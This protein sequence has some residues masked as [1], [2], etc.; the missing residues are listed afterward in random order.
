[1]YRKIAAEIEKSDDSLREELNTLD[2]KIDAAATQESVNILQEAVTNLTR[3]V[4]N[5]TTL[6]ENNNN[7]RRVPPNAAD[8]HGRGNLHGGRG[9]VAARGIQ[10][11]H[12]REDDGLGKP[13][14]SIPTLTCDAEDVEEY[15]MWELKIEKLWRLHDYSEE[16]K[17]KLA[18]SGFEGYALLWWDSLTELR[19]ENEEPEI[20][21]WG[22]MKHLLRDRFVPK[23]YIRTLYDKL[24]QLKQGTKSVD[25]YYKEMELILQRARVR[26][27]PDQT[28]QRFLSGL[29]FMRHLVSCNSWHT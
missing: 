15:L 25:A 28:M 14:F 6:L 21:T 24:Q 16:R 22:E 29:Q 26:E 12:N 9:G 1:M 23:N 4:A 20:A 3:Q 13:K 18:S 5:L 27:A 11:E 7:Q 10:L 19:A 2:L 17:I 8:L